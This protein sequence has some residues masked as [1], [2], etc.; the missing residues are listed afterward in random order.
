MLLL[1]AGYRGHHGLCHDHVCGRRRQYWRRQHDWRWGARWL[2][3]HDL[4]RLRLNH[5]RRGLERVRLLCWNPITTAGHLGTRLW[6]NTIHRYHLIGRSRLSCHGALAAR[7][8][9][10]GSAAIG[11]GHRHRLLP[12]GTMGHHVCLCWLR[13]WCWCSLIA[14]VWVKQDSWARIL[15]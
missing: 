7:G 3:N 2:Q 14:S 10:R 13:L 9:L 15:A 6:G 1:A 5:H 4:R 8:G 12:R 11:G